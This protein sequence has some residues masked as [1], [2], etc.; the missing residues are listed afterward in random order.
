LNTKVIVVGGGISGLSAAY[1]LGK[2]GLRAT[3]VEKAAKPGGV[4]QTELRHGCLLEAGPDSFLAT[5]PW[6]LELIDQ[7]GLSDQVIGSN[8][9]LRVT[10]VARGGQLVPLPDGLMMMVP[11]KVAPMVRTRLFTWRTK[12]RM[13]LDL[14]HWPRGEHSDDRSVYDF[15]IGH[16]GE[17]AIDYLAEPLLAGVY[18][19]DPRELSAKS[20]LPRFVALEAKYGSLTR[21]VL[22]M[23]RSKASGS[24]FQTLKGGL[25]QLVDALA[26]SADFTRGEAETI[27]MVATGFRVRVGGHWIH[28]DEVVIATPAH[29]AAALVRTIDGGLANLLT[30]IPYMSSI[31]LSLGYERSAFGH[32][33]RGFGFLVPKR[34]RKHLVACTWVNNKFSY[35]VPEDMVLLRCF[36]S[37]SALKESDA[38]LVEMARDELQALMGITPEPVFS[39]IA[40]WPQSMAQYTVGHEDRVEEIESRLQTIPGLHLAGNAY[41]GIGVPDCVRMGK[42]AATQVIE[43][44]AAIIS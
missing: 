1:Y 4:I 40:R 26:P 25:G 44:R 27:E 36:M 9:H 13:G 15:L 35:R 10:Y 21:G 37:G 6:A 28:A 16:F 29:R 41:H 39:K 14:F 3:I 33:L 17:E 23:P 30:A 20:V 31:T 2:A 8:D 32:P 5:K 19:G 18:G 34:E 7:L 38:S 43:R 12:L 11:T 24:L 42:D 22:A